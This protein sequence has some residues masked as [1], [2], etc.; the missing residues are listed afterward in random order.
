MSN[1]YE[2]VITAESIAGNFSIS[3]PEE[4]D[5][6]IARLS[7]C[8]SILPR[9]ITLPADNAFSHGDRVMCIDTGELPPHIRQE[10]GN[11]LELIVDAS[12]KSEP[13]TMALWYY[14][15]LNKKRITVESRHF[16]RV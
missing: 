15:G 8:A 16:R 3:T 1:P 2:I 5:D 12:V 10:I 14:V 13:G 11:V 9:L 7:H 6:F 4:A